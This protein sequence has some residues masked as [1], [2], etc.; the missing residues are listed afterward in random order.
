MKGKA[1]FLQSGQEKGKKSQDQGERGKKSK[2]GWTGKLKS[3]A[4]PTNESFSTTKDFAA[5]RT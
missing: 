4:R 5:L 1:G 3:A 2:G